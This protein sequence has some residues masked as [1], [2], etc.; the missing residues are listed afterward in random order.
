MC[1]IAGVVGM[2]DRRSSAAC[3]QAMIGT[4]ARRG[5]DGEGL[6]QWNDATFAHRRLAIFDLSSAGSQ[7][8]LTADGRVGVVFN[9]AIYNFRELREELRR[10]G[11]PFVSQTDTEV[12]LHG[13]L[14]WGVDELVRRLRGMFAFALWDDRSKALYLVRDRVGVK[15]LAYAIR[16]DVL[17]FA[18]T[19]RALRAAGFAS[20]LNEDAVKAFLELGYLA[21]DLSIYQGV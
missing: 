12:L 14:E 16:G 19:P 3:A 7:P 21:D 6:E 15:P 1:A 9:G 4:L 2:R 8:M 13:Y 17:A 18:S 5:P 20:E 10:R 11:C